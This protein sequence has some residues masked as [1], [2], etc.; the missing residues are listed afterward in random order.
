MSHFIIT[1]RKI[2]NRKGKEVID[3]FLA[4]E[5][6][7]H[8]RCGEIAI[9]KDENNA[10]T[11]YPD[12]EE[13]PTYT[14]DPFD[15]SSVNNN[16]GS[17]QMFK[18]LC[19]AL[20]KAAA[21]K[22]DV[23]FFIHGYGN[24]LDRTYSILK[25]LH[26]QYVMR[27]DCR[28]GLTVTLSWPSQTIPGLGYK[29]QQA[30][31]ELSGRALARLYMRLL[32]YREMTGNNANIHLICQ[33][34]G[35]HLLMETVRTLGKIAGSGQSIRPL[36]KEVLLTGAD[37]DNDALE[38]GKDYSRVIELGERV[39]VYY[40]ADDGVLEKSYRK[41]HRKN[42]GKHRLG[43][44]GPQDK[45]KIPAGIHLVDTTAVN[46]YKHIFDFDH[47]HFILSQRVIADITKVLNGEKFT[48]TMRVL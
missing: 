16:W 12:N 20:D 23:L 4:G 25:G 40:G 13:T 45:A 11:F 3:R 34:M 43:F 14:T 36:F 5:A 42:G 38:T 41:F 27:A 8:L 47:M 6:T 32:K 18:K 37:V 7:P 9:D 39:H 46:D 1:S 15:H 30:D 31:A 2:I 48:S 44:T 24:T 29:R 21:E 28:A 33:S 26:L 35:N 10:F 17:M 19:R 22:K